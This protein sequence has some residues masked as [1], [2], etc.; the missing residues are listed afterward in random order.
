MHISN[1]TKKYRIVSSIVQG[2]RFSEAVSEELVQD[3]LLKYWLNIHNLTSAEAEIPWLIK[4]AKNHCNSHYHKRK[5]KL[6][7]ELP[8]EEPAALDRI[9]ISCT[10]EES[11][12]HEE[13]IINLRKSIHDMKDGPAKDVMKAFYITGKPVK[14][15]SLIYNL[16]PN[17]VL[18]HLRRGR[19][20]IRYAYAA[21][22]S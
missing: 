4:I 5:R 19:N 16:K 2:Y 21:Y 1:L 14:A 10:N 18:S 3:I 17:T 20:K 22:N 13:D 12:K 8:F 6:E 7:I 15:I 9:T 11:M